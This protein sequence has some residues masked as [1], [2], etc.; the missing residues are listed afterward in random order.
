MQT[1]PSAILL[2]LWSLQMS[3]F[4]LPAVAQKGAPVSDSPEITLHSSS[5][6]VVVDVIAL[7]AKIGLPDKTLKRDDFRI[8][9][10]GQPVSINTF[11]SGAKFTTRPLALWFVVQCNMRGYEA[12]GSGLFAGKISLLKR[13]LKDLE[14]Q[15]T[16]AVAHWCDDGQSNLDV[17]PTSDIDET[18]T[19][20]EQV[21]VPMPDTNDHG[22]TGEL[23]LQ[24]TLQL[25]ID[26]THSLV[27]E[28]LPVVIF[29]YGDYSGMD[30]SEAN[31]FIDELLETSAVAYGLRDVRS[32]RIWL[33]GEQGAVA[34]YIATQTGGQYLRV[35][36]KTYAK[37]LEEIL[38]QLHCRYELGFKPQALDGKRHKLRVE[39]AAAAK[40]RHKGV[41]LRSRA[42]YVP[43]ALR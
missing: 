27:P 15:D 18:A 7:S 28:P 9:D 17:L 16:V 2:L 38:Q 8:F 42:A 34:N 29:L 36:P 33:I 3:F 41:R 13:P 37:G 14:K 12:K 23:A 1:K 19:T 39:L 35:T 10:N 32:P 24:K 31:H 25:I 43:V 26:A 5:N 6:L 22:R 20:L 40:S 11:D 4:T 30:R 21:L